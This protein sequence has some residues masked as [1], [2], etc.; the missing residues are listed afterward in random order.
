M[1]CTKGKHNTQPDKEE[2]KMKWWVVEIADEIDGFVSVF[3]ETADEAE[4]QARDAGYDVM[5]GLG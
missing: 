5:Y 3:A 1:K 4:E 2:E